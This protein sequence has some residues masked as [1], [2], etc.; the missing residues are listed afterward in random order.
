MNS[1]YQTEVLNEE[2]SPT[3][4]FAP[5][6]RGWYLPVMPNLECSS[7]HHINQNQLPI[8]TSRPKFLI[9]SKK[10][11]AVCIGV[12]YKKLKIDDANS[13]HFVSWEQLASNPFLSY[14]SIT[15]QHTI[16]IWD[17]ST[18]TVVAIAS[19]WHLPGSAVNAAAANS[20][21]LRQSIRRAKTSHD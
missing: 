3:G 15:E 8:T 13:L 7:F 12:C 11:I 20:H 1:P 5:V 6:F 21:W 16:T 2:K 17:T 14:C 4:S 18:V 10:P 19:S 9:S